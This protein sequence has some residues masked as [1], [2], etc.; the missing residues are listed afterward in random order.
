VP[1]V[2]V[3]SCLTCHTS[4]D[5]GGCGNQ[6][7]DFGHAFQGNSNAW[8]GSL[9]AGDADGDSFPD[10]WELQ[11]PT[12]AWSTGSA[13]PGNP[14]LVSNPGDGAS[15]PPRI[16]VDPTAIVH[17]EVAGANGFETFTV[18]NSGGSCAGHP[19]GPCSLA[20]DVTSDVVWVSPDPPGGIDT[21][22]VDLLFSTGTLAEGVYDGT[23]TV[24]AAGV[25]NSP[26]SVPVTLTVPEPAGLPLRA[27]A[28]LSLAWMAR[29]AR[30]GGARSRSRGAT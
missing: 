27:A 21:T 8:S 4:L 22:L 30:R 11:D 5:P 17:G 3:H 7:N 20:F 29:R 13:D 16:S 2:V 26:V 9:A 28:L 18:Q 12:G 19:S 15:S 1:N 6:C 24:S 25:I 10:G 23:A 14:A